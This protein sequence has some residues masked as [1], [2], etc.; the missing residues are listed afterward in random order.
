MFLYSGVSLSTSFVTLQR[1]VLKNKDSNVSVSVSV[2]V[3]E[4]IGVG[5][6]HVADDCLRVVGNEGEGVGGLH[7][8][9]GDTAG[10]SVKTGRHIEREHRQ[11]G[12]VD[13]RDPVAMG[14]CDGAREADAE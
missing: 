5:K 11:A 14:R 7:A 9:T 2:G 10:I 6:S 8:H 3:G 4:G 1:K 12:G 13:G